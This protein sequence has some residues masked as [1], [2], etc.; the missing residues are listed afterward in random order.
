[1][2]M[3]LLLWLVVIDVICGCGWWV[4]MFVIDG[5]WCDWWFLL[6]VIDVIDGYW[7]KWWL[8]MM[9]KIIDVIDYWLLKVI[10]VNDGYW[11]D[12]WL[13]MWLIVIDAIDGCYWSLLMCLMVD[14][15]V[16]D[17]W[18]YCDWWLTGWHWMLLIVDVIGGWCYWRLA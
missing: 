16:S 8:W 11:C 7:C 3:V 5:Y 4:L 9:G 15:A 18:C 13:L 6:I 17:N 1:M 14:V 2:K 10:D 12:W